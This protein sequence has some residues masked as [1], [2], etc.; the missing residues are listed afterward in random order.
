MT[1]TDK[2]CVKPSATVTETAQA[3]MKPSATVT[4]IVNAFVE[5]IVTITVTAMAF[6]KLI[7][8][9]TVTVTLGPRLG[10]QARGPGIGPSAQAAAPLMPPTP[11]QIFLAARSSS[12]DD[13]VGVLVGWSVMLLKF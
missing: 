2:A 4:V 11:P 10:A 9:V 3:Y 5:V 13:Y 8:S 12:I 7:V 6:V 1:E